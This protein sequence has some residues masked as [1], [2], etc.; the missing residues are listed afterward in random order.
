MT[1][2]S[3]IWPHE[4]MAAL[5]AFYGDP[6][7]HAG[8]AN[9]AWVAANLIKIIPPYRMEYSGGGIMHALWVHK[10]CR[11]AFMAALEGILAHYGSQDAIEAA[12]MHLTGGTFCYRLQR[13]G[14]RLSV[15]SWACAI[16]MDPARN[17]FPRAW[18]PGKGMIPLEAAKIFE[19]AGFTWRGAGSDTD[20]MHFQLCH[21]R[22]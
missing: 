1:K 7:G 5:N 12:R 11:D 15:H 17:P 19:A 14:S 20:P 13:G 21:R 4:D 2:S 18:R 3:T 16:D 9:P 8:D 10:K 22:R 6:R